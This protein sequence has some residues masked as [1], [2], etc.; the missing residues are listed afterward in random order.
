MY[1]FILYCFE[2]RVN[3]KQHLY[4]IQS[5]D[6]LLRLYL[7]DY[8]EYVFEP[9]VYGK[10][11]PSTLYKVGVTSTYALPS[12]DPSCRITLNMLLSLLLLL[13]YCI[14]SYCN[15]FVSFSHS[16]C[17]AQ[18]NTLGSLHIHQL[19]LAQKQEGKT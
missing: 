6:T 2:S 1:R 16:C 19:T 7:W 8:T 14:V 4:L 18:L 15:I 12:S 3:Q 13:L 11:P 9:R 5:K 17:Y 10:Q